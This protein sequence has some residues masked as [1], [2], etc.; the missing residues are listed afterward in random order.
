M[1]T[2]MPEA[3]QP[4]RL[5]RT[6]AVQLCRTAGIPSDKRDRFIRGVEKFVASYL[7]WKQQKTALEAQN[8]LE[9]LRK[10]V[11]RC[12]QRLD[13]TTW[14]PGEY[15]KDLK[16]IS[17]TLR[18][19]SQPARELMRNAPIVHAIPAGWSPGLPSREVVDPICFPRDEDQFV[20]LKELLGA[21]AGPFLNKVAGRP[22]KY[23]EA[24]L[25]HN[26][27]GS[28]SRDTGGK[29]ASDSSTDFM[30]LCCEIK[31]MFELDDWRPGS[32]ARSA[33]K[34]RAT[35]ESLSHHE[36]DHDELDDGEMGADEVLDIIG[37]PE[38]AAKQSKL[39]ARRSSGS[40]ARR[41][42]RRRRSV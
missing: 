28:Y 26:L 7:R 30:A 10:V 4:I 21:L 24:A 37:Q 14:R 13:H 31:S 2:P 42:H 3:S 12:L 18:N 9:A 11:T 40:G 33:H 39:S 27:A 8:E 35:T 16:V 1:G 34:R 38:A 22:E 29:A 36:A 41:T 5:T 17:S 15:R 25:Y 20:A 19:L 23:D 6:Q 32:L